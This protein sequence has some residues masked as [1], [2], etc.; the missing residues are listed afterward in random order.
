MSKQKE[1]GLSSLPDEIRALGERIKETLPRYT[2][3]LKGLSGLPSEFDKRFWVSCVRA[4]LVK[5]RADHQKWQ[6]QAPSAGLAAKLTTLALDVA[7][8]AAGME[9]IAP[10]PYPEVGISIS[11]SGIIK[12][13]LLNYPSAEP[14]V[15]SVT[16]E[17]FEAIAR[18]VEDEIMKGTATP[19][20][21]E[22]IPKLI[23][24]AAS[25]VQ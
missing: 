19:E 12:P 11:P 20:S 5:V 24:A 22:D 7:L 21:E 8:K 17:K 23:Y 9:P 1:Q 14:G 4:L 10:P 3:C 15:I 16:I 6:A 25:Q 18:K 2:A 13:T